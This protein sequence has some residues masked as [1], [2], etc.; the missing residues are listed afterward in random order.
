MWMRQL[1]RRMAC[2]IL[3]MCAFL[4]GCDRSNNDAANHAASPAAQSAAASP[5]PP[6]AP[7]AYRAIDPA[8][9]G[10]TLSFA[11]HRMSWTAD[12]SMSGDLSDL[13]AIDTRPGAN[14]TK[15]DIALATGNAVDDNVETRDLGIIKIRGGFGPLVISMTDASI[16]KVREALDGA[17]KHGQPR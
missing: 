11:S 5:A 15:L 3:G 4:T 8:G 17:A 1:F 6:P 2:L 14:G 9:D 16:K 12:G 13:V 7:P 10:F